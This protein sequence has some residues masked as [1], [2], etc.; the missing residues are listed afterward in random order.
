MQ[1][2]K[3]RLE[4]Y[5]T[6]IL[7]FGGQHADALDSLSE[8]VPRR[9]AENKKLHRKIA[10]NASPVWTQTKSGLHARSMALPFEP[11]R[12]IELFQ[13]IVRGLMFYH[14]GVRLTGEHSLEVMLIASDKPNLFDSLLQ[15][16]AKDHVRGN[17][18]NGTFLYDGHQGIDNDAISAWRFSAYGGLKETGYPDIPGEHTSQIGALTGPKRIF[19]RADRHAKWTQPVSIRVFRP[20]YE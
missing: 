5:L 20:P 14:L 2:R 17:L 15:Q 16:S 12:L 1:R 9:L 8:M 18:G 4:H 13:Y 10:R 3:A 11:E 6:A 7:P 19:E